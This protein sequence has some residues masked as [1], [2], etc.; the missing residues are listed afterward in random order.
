MREMSGSR[1]RTVSFKTLNIEKDLA[2][3]KHIDA[4]WLCN[5]SGCFIDTDFIIRCHD[6]FYQSKLLRNWNCIEKAFIVFDELL[7]IHTK[8]FNQIAVVVGECYVM[9]ANGKSSYGFAFNPPY[10]FHAWC[11][12]ALNDGCHKPYIIDLAMPGV[13]EYG[14]IQRDSY[15]PLLTGRTPMYVC[16]TAPEWIY[17]KPVKIAKNHLVQPPIY[18][19]EDTTG[20]ETVRDEFIDEDGNFYE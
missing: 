7:K 9:S 12:V 8:V 3:D 4:A 20:R 2:V 18:K 6:L 1:M 16:G 19:A 11:S 5:K 10:E 13:I 14:T 15:G 17:Y